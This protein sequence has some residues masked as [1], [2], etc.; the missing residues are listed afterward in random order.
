MK[1]KL[2]LTE[3]TNNIDQTISSVMQ[4]PRKN[5]QQ[6]HLDPQFKF[7]ENNFDDLKFLYDHSNSDKDIAKAK[8]IGP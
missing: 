1:Q 6:S 8:S 4:E 7:W 5:I 3:L 2:L